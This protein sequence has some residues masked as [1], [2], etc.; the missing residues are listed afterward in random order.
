VDKTYY[1]EGLDPAIA[2]AVEEAGELQ[3]ALGKAIRFGLESVNPELPPEEQERNID[4]VRREAE[5]VIEAAKNLLFEL[6]LYTLQKYAEERKFLSNFEKVQEFMRVGEQA[7]PDVPTI[8]PQNIKD[9]RVKLLREELR[10][11]A[12]A[13]ETNDMIGIADGVADLLYVTYGT[14]EAYGLP[15]DDIFA[16]VHRSN[17]TKFPDG[18][19]IK[20]SHGKIIKPESFV[21]PDLKPIL[22]SYKNRHTYVDV[23]KGE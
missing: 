13:I 15:V 14:G 10:E 2:T 7:G 17:M 6:D 21:A 22:D 19:A 4:W 1:V 12:E 23:D 16:E 20:N 3:A 9:L 11:L 5:D 8:P 18:K